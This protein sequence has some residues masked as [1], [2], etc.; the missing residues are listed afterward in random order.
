MVAKAIA[1]DD[2]QVGVKTLA[3]VLAMAAETAVVTKFLRGEPVTI[4]ARFSLSYIILTTNK[5]L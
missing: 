2:A 4:Q 3:R 1:L 5:I